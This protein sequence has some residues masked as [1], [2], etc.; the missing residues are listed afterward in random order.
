[1][2]ISA[3]SISTSGTITFRKEIVTQDRKLAR[4][5]IITIVWT[6]NPSS[7]ADGSWGLISTRRIH[8]PDTRFFFLPAINLLLHDRRIASD[9]TFASVYPDR[10]LL[11]AGS[12]RVFYRIVLHQ[13]ALLLV[14]AFKYVLVGVI[15]QNISPLAF[16][17]DETEKTTSHAK[18]R[19]DPRV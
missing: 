6:C 11:V 13:C 17:A 2:R 15:W 1:M 3:I 16:L 9:W 4:R 12:I 19:C 7:D 18:P 8:F 14:D 10:R 5:R